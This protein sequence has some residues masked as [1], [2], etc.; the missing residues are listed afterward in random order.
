V[1]A[2]ATA[3]S[4]VRDA[5]AARPTAVSEER[6]EGSV[7]AASEVRKERAAEAKE[8]SAARDV[9][10]AVPV[11]ASECGRKGAAVSVA[12]AAGAEE[13]NEGSVEAASE[14][15]SEGA[16]A[17]GAGEPRGKSWSCIFSILP[18]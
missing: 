4:A 8:A 1:S 11:V 13:R 12:R 15:R 16:A 3:R 6:N 10:A 18:R 5:G 14:E 2:E 7:E 9:G 17:V